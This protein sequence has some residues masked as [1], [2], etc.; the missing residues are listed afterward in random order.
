MVIKAFQTV[1][2]SP[3]VL[4][5]EALL[6]V[7]SLANAVGPHF[8]RFM[9]HFAP[10]LRV[11]LQNYEDVQVCLM[12]TH[13]VSNLCHAL[14]GKILMYC[15]SILETLYSNLQNPVV[16]R[17]IKP[18]IMSCFGDI[19]L[20]ITGDFEK[21][22]APVVRMLHEASS[23]RLH[24]VASPNEE[25]VEYLNS[26]REGV[27]EAYTGI[28]H[29]LRDAQKLH[30]F[31]EHVNAVLHFVKE[32]TGDSSV[33]EPVMK[34]AVGVIG[35]LVLVFQQELT[36]HLGNAPFLVTL[37]ECASRSSDPGMRQTATWLQSLLQKYQA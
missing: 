1:K 22:L 35:D 15:D 20:A 18:A 25:W 3:H 16:E 5:E 7:A 26:L 10:H 13:V 36:A 4:Q 11:G 2:G 29:G 12:S 31:K 30:L 28:I 17:K 24:H 27:L 34:A 9:P 32:I 6:L 14:K 21:Y 19:A 33:S 23:T 37:V 8:E